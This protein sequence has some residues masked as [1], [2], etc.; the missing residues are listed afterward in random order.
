VEEVEMGPE[1]STRDLRQNKVLIIAENRRGHGTGHF[2]RCMRLAGELMQQECVVEW[3]L[4]YKPAENGYTLSEIAE[5]LHEDLS[6]VKSTKNLS[7]SYEVLVID[8]RECPQELLA[9]M[10]HGCLSIAIDPRGDLRTYSDCV[11]DTMPLDRTTRNNS[12][13]QESNITDTAFQYRPRNRRAAWPSK[14]RRVIV[15]FGGEDRDEHTIAV[16]QALNNSNPDTVEITAVLHNTALQVSSSIHVRPP[17][18]DIAE[19][20]HCY[21]LVVSHFGLTLWEALWARVP[22]I[23]LNPTDYHN[24]L[25]IAAG[26]PA[27]RDTTGLLDLA[28]KFETVLHQCVSIPIPEQRSL[29]A[30]IAESYC[31]DFRSSFLID[32]KGGPKSQF[33]DKAIQRFSDR[34]FFRHS[35]TGLIYMKKFHGSQIT[36][37]HDY[38]FREYQQQY[39]RT[40][41]EDFPQIVETCRRRVADIG[42]FVSPVNSQIESVESESVGT[43]HSDVELGIAKDGGKHGRSLR[44]ARPHVIDV[45]CAYGPFLVAATEAGWIAEGIDLNAEAVDYIKKTLK[46]PARAVDLMTMRREDFIHKPNIITMWYVIEHVPQLHT[47]LERIAH[48]L[49]EGGLF[50]FSTPHCGGIS[51]RRNQRAFLEQSPRDHVTIWDKSSARAVLRFHGFTVVH[52]RVTGHHP[53]R[54][55]RYVPRWLYPMVALW[56][57]ICGLGDTFEIIA[58]REAS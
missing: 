7:Q 37:D 18:P 22:V 1:Q 49:P 55:S 35:E 9:R 34:T 21:D 26:M 51:F 50:A 38:F 6:W 42:R 15:L 14:L 27:Y 46:L 4:P 33:V 11:I 47:L 16:S 56:S 41:L 43:E 57:Q 48:I 13:M 5:L 24:Q 53:E 54:F 52:I 2:R 32:G 40:Y 29:G 39:G 58:R 28:S 45:G 3:C 10:P 8:L 23:S 44:G 30:F 20:L 19:E 12:A 25:A 17:S 36:Y 31:P